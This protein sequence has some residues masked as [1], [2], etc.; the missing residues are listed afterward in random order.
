M[1][2]SKAALAL[3]VGYSAGKGKDLFLEFQCGF[4]RG[5]AASAEAGFDNEER[6]AKVGDETVAGWERMGFGCRFVEEGGK[7]A[8]LPTYVAGE[9]KVFGGV[10][11]IESMAEHPDGG[12]PIFDRCLVCDGVDPKG[13]TAKNYQ[14]GPGE[15]ANKVC[16]YLFAV[17]A[18]LAGAG[19]SDDI[20]RIQV[21]VSLIE[22][23][24]RCFGK[25][26]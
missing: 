20:C 14:I 5:K 2:E 13:E 19:D 12:E 1:D 6:V 25:R 23:D 7:Q 3:F 15:F 21:S 18:W 8:A 26:E 22:E 9:A 16:G 17:F 11:V 10:E 4:G 24:G